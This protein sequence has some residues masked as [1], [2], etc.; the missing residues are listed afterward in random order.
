M[1]PIRAALEAHRVWPFVEGTQPQPTT[2]SE[3]TTW[4]QDDLQA[5]GLILC[6]CTAAIQQELLTESASFKRIEEVTAESVTIYATTAEGKSTASTTPAAT[7]TV[8]RS[9]AKHRWDYLEKK[10]RGGTDMAA[11]M[12]CKTLR[13]FHFV[14]GT[15]YEEQLNKIEAIYHSLIGTQFEQSNLNL[16]THVLCALPPAYTIVIQSYMGT[17]NGGKVVYA[18]V[19]ARILD[20]E[21]R[22]KATSSSVVNA[23]RGH[24]AKECR[25][26]KFDKKKDKEGGG[27]GKGTGNNPKVNVVAAESSNTISFAAYVSPDQ[28]WMLDS[29]CSHHVTH[30]LHD[31]S[32]YTPYSTPRVLTLGDRSTIPYL[33]EGTVEGKIASRG[34]T[35]VLTLTNV[36]YAPKVGYRFIST[37]MLDRKGFTLVHEKGECRIKKGNVEVGTG[38]LRDHNYWLEMEVQ[39]ATINAAKSSPTADIWHQRF[40][41]VSPSTLTRHINDSAAVKGIRFPESSK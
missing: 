39:S 35:V 2:L 19:K 10:Y 30:S 40:A 12:R 33:G 8:Y 32:S 15:P 29:G 27:G 5:A 25:K 41:H 36:L 38:R 11:M 20:E 4:L 16:A 21:L 3:Q 34:R 23:V 37:G 14:E 24:W 1:L 13:E 18:D 6:T 31:F 28:T 7:R 17:L 22:K 26:R 9:L